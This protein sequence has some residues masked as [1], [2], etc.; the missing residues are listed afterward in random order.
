MKTL[1][2]PRSLPLIGTQVNA[3]RF[4]RDPALFMRHLQQTYGDLVAMA[5][6]SH[7]YVFAF[8]P[9][10]NQTILSNPALFLNSAAENSPIRIPPDTAFATMFLNGLNQMNEPRHKQQRRLL[11]PAFHKQQIEGYASEMIALAES[12]LAG[13]HKGETRNMLAEM[14]QLT[15]SIALKVLLGMEPGREAAA[16]IARFEQWQALFFHPLAILLPFNLPGSPYGRLLKLSESFVAETQAL[17]D[18]KRATPPGPDIL[19]LLLHTHDEDG[20]RLTDAEL[21]AQTATLFIAGHETTASA[22][23][24][25]LLLLAQHPAVL[26]ELRAELAPLAG[27][28]PTLAQL[29]TLPLLEGVLKESMRLFPPFYWQLRILAEATELDGAPLPKGG[30]VAFS[31]FITHRRPELYPQPDLFLP[32]RWQNVNPSPYEYFPFSAGPRMCLGATFAMMEMRLILP[33]IV[34]RFSFQLLPNGRI[35]RRGLVLSSPD[36]LPMKLG[37]PTQKATAVPLRGS[38]ADLFQLHESPFP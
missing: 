7:Q 27:H 32:H 30:V 29:P 20:T 26:E 3:F 34:Q 36:T 12:Q 24:W 25:T 22:L 33:L 9:A 21:I 28:A 31:S 10:H 14:R 16:A 15:A 5:H 18:R 4:M 6:G 8:T 13:W 35:H 2:G 23:A 11:M 1:P 37:E 38:A 19:S 17:I